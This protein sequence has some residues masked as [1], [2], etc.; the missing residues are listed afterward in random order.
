MY[1][2]S[3]AGVPL[4]VCLSLA[5][6]R[7]LRALAC[8]MATIELGLLGPKTLTWL[9]NNPYCTTPAS[10]SRSRLLQQTYHLVWR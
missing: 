1:N 6:S 2:Q 10:P 9:Y 5:T 3:E 7:V 8:T 4:A